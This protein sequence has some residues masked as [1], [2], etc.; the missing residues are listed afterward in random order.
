MDLMCGI[1]DQR[2]IH[3]SIV[4]GVLDRQAAPL[5]TLYRKR[6]HVMETTLRDQ[7]GDRIS[8]MQPKGGFFLWAR[9]PEGY[10]CEPL[11]EKSLQEGVIFV[12]GSA[13]CVDGSGHDRV[14]LS[15]SWPTP[16]RIV[17]GAVRLS[18]AMTLSPVGRV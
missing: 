18:R 3:E 17:E 11:L 15:F 6:R 10:D 1:L 14:R 13:F 12:I 7:F 16:D 8:W 4:R 9:L 2:V 5:R